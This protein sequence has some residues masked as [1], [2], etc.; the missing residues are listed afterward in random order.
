MARFLQCALQSEGYAVELAFD[1]EQGLDDIDHR[2]WHRHRRR[3]P[4]HEP[5]AEAAI[6]HQR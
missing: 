4:N 1:G 2:V 6:R 5:D 3:H